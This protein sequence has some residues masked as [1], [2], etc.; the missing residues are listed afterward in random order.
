MRDF[1][2]LE[3]WQIGKEIAVEVVDI[4]DEI[5]MTNQGSKYATKQMMRHARSHRISRKE[6]RVGA[7]RRSTVTSNTLWVLRSSCKQE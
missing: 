1:P 6:V 3:M 7:K 4:L 2:K 5:P